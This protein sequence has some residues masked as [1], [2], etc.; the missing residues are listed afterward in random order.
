MKLVYC[1]AGKIDN[2]MYSVHP[3]LSISIKAT[4][5]VYQ[6]P[7]SGSVPNYQKRKICQEKLLGYV[8]QA[9]IFIYLS[10]RSLQTEKRRK[11]IV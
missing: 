4:L 3:S 6:S 10:N 8:F 9:S 7:N 1:I 2:Q 5:G 11:L